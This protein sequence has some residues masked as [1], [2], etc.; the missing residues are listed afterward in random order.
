MIY[1]FTVTV[2]QHK[3]VN[4]DQQEKR[5]FLERTTREKTWMVFCL[6]VT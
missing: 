5:K 2:T 3:I 4:W 6:T 1:E